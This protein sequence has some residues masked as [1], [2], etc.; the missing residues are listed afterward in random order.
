MGRRD[1]CSIRSKGTRKEPCSI[2]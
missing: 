2:R 1:A